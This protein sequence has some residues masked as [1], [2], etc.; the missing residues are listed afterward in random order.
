VEN[1]ASARTYSQLTVCVRVFY[2]FV[3]RPKG[4]NGLTRFFQ[5]TSNVCWSQV[6]CWRTRTVIMSCCRAVYWVRYFYSERL[7]F[8]VRVKFP[9]NRCLIVSIRL[10]WNPYSISC[11]SLFYTTVCIIVRGKDGKWD[12]RSRATQGRAIYRS[13]LKSPSRVT[14]HFLSR[15]CVRGK[16]D[17]GIYANSTKTMEKNLLLSVTS[18]AIVWERCKLS[19]FKCLRI[20][21]EAYNVWIWSKVYVLQGPWFTFQ[22]LVVLGT[23]V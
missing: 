15:P 2:Y 23:L 5:C 20:V 9:K 17:V 3:D 7:A 18:N 6:Y 21:K 22:F 19:M 12:I 14:N 1:V 4:R 10:V 11:W 16:V 13:R 8:T